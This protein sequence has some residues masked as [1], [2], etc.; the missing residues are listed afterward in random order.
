MEMQKMKN[1][2]EVIDAYQKES[3]LQSF[4]QFIQSRTHLK[5]TFSADQQRYLT[6]QILASLARMKWYKNG[7]FEVYNQLDPAFA[8][9]IQ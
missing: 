9:M 3:T 6:Q 2:K 4:I 8:K 1:P 7:Y 5:K